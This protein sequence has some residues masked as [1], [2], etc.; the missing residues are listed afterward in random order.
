[1]S[2]REN[3]RARLSQ[4]LDDL[5]RLRKRGGRRVWRSGPRLH[6]EVR[7][8]PGDGGAFAAGLEAAVGALRGVER[9]RLRPDLGVLVVDLGAVPGTRRRDT[10]ERAMLRFE[11]S[12]IDAMAAIE[13]AYGLGEKPLP[14]VAQ[15]ERYPGDGAPIARTALEL[16]FDAASMAAALALRSV[17]IGVRPFEFDLGALQSLVRNVPFVRRLVERQLSGALTE[18]GLEL[19]DAVLQALMQGQ[20][21]TA[22]NSLH[23]SLRLRE[24][25]ARKRLWAQWEPRLCGAAAPAAAPPVPRPGELPEG[26]FEHYAER[27][28]LGSLGAFG[29][30]LL[31]QGDFEN[32]TAAI[33]G[34]IPRPARLGRAAFAAHL[35]YK[36]A[37]AGVLVMQPQVLRQFDRLDCIAIGAALLDEDA[38]SAARLTRTIL[39]AQLKLVVLDSA[40]AAEHEAG[41]VRHLAHGGAAAVRALQEEGQGVAYFGRGA[42]GAYATAD[43][44]V[45][46]W[47]E[48]G[49]PPLGAHLHCDGGLEHVIALVEAMAAAREA[50]EQLLQLSLA[51]VALS[52]ALSAGG[53]KEKTTRR[54][55]TAAGAASIIAI[56]DGLRLAHGLGWPGPEALRVAATAWHRLPVAEV[57]QQL[58]SGPRGLDEAQAAARRVPRPQPPPGPLQLAQAVIEELRNPMTPVLAAGAGLSLLSGGAVDAL[59]VAAVIAANAAYGGAERY[60]TERLVRLLSQR[61]RLQLRVRRGKTVETIED[62]RLVAGDVIELAAGDVVP[63]DCRIIEA[64]NLEVDESSLTGESLP[65]SKTTE[66]A[67]AGE[68]AERHCMLYDGTIVA[69]GR[70]VAAV[71]AVG[72]DTE[73][74]RAGA[75][76][77]GVTLSV[78]VEARLQALTRMATPIAAASAL[79]LAAGERVSGRSLREVLS[80]AV[81]LAV[82]AVPEGLPLMASLAQLTVAGRLAERGALVRNP[83]AV[84]ALGRVDLLC[85]DKTGT[86]TEGQI[87]LVL[88]SDGTREQAPGSLDMHLRE[89][90]AA[91]LRASPSTAGEAP[92]THMT[93]RALI[94]GAQTAAVGSHDGL[95]QWQRLH[96]MPFESS[97]G[98][99]A[100][101]A[102]HGD[103]KLISVKGAPEVVLA[104]CTRRRRG[105]RDTAL[106]EAQKKRLLQAAKRIADR[107]YRVLAVA[108]REAHEHRPIDLRRVRD[109][110]FR[111]FIAFADPVR[112]SARDSLARLRSAG[113]E[114]V[115]LTGDHPSTAAAIAAEL[116]LSGDRRV[117]TGAELETLDDAGLAAL[118][119]QV[120]VFARVTPVHK[121]RIVKAFQALGRTVAMTGD[122]ANDAPAIRLADVGI[123]LGG[124]ST[125]AARSAADLV[126]TDGRVETIVEAVL[127]GR[128]LWLS[129]R[130]AVTLLVGGNLG[131]IGFTLAAGLLGRRAPLNARQL[132]LVNLITDALPALAVALRPPRG[133]TPEALL[134][135]GPD[136]SFGPELLRE[137]GLR[138]GVTAAVSTGAWAV[139]R[140]GGRRGAAT[141]GLLAL[142]GTQLIQALAAGRGDRSVTLASLGSLAT[143][144]AVVETPGLSQFFGCR[145][146]GPLGLVQ[147]AAA[148]AVGGAAQ[149]AVPGA[150]R[151]L[152]RRG[153]RADVGERP[154]AAKPKRQRS[155]PG[156]SQTPRARTARRGRGKRA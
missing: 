90:L 16:G 100:G 71:V 117:V 3:A 156:A 155:I 44:G 43:C 127:A 60:R 8:A 106:S 113:I 129:V 91:A 152:R 67:D 66:P 48:H 23:R 15:P 50:T 108:E 52:L 142:T 115:M 65:V 109:L 7:D 12:V 110:G 33:F 63:A 85:V 51:E 112:P 79:A 36:L 53:I 61:E 139:A 55:V 146:V 30:T 26:P 134:D 2:I 62:D 4:Y 72:A 93:D 64:R 132:L 17:G 148:I 133:K 54:V 46:L 147:A 131:E 145:P 99:H 153:Q 32:A 59:L 19:S 96:E 140:L 149:L 25:R 87:K 144:L 74:G 119:P 49:E 58:G 111:G 102:E 103:G 20:F 89:V 138:A 154:A 22:A 126:V 84:E 135:A 107:G 120:C 28:A 105:G 104:H 14:R 41:A 122:G 68:L 151:W 128:A 137:L 118:L 136:A 70:A 9:A 97:R 77:D 39:D 76:P 86:L 73:A 21:G 29:A 38:A 125:A 121:V 5:Q 123:A 83:R 31:A 27:A 47:A 18:I 24:L 82:A 37:R 150:D 11:D 69:A 81:S 95:S 88:V 40:E 1:M 6:V 34:G 42:S 13:T 94:D 56:A 141:V 92:P 10:R 130:D 143:V 45:G 114:T 124:R 57:L 101:L 78:G 98:F 75:V 80:T 116:G 35:G